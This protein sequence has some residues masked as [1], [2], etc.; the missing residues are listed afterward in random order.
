MSG[1][2]TIA[3]DWVPQSGEICDGPSSPGSHRQMQSDPRPE[4]DGQE[5]LPSLLPSPGQWKKGKWLKLNQYNLFIYPSVA[6]SGASSPS[7]A[8]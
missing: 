3:W 8:H 5:P 4:R 2:I 7:G 6:S 1:E